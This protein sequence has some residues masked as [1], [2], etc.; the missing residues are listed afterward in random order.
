MRRVAASAVTIALLSACQSGI[1]SSSTSSA[2]TSSASTTSATTSAAASNAPGDW[3]APSGGPT[4]NRTTTLDQITPQNVSQLSKAWVTDVRDDGEE[5]SNPIETGDTVYITT[6]HDNVLA[7]DATSGKLKWAFGY[8]PQYELQYPVNRGVALDNGKLFLF[9]Q[10]CKLVALDASTGKAAF[11][12]PACHDTSNTWYSSAAYVYKGNVIVGTSGGD[13]G[14]DGLISAFS[15]T[16]GHRLWDWNTVTHPG[17][18][19]FGTWP[20]NSWQHGGA[21]VWAGLSAGADPDTIYAAPGNPEPNLTTYGHAGKNLY[22]DSVVALDISGSKPSLKWYHQIMQGDTHDADPAMPPVIFDGSVNGSQ[23]QLLAVGDKGGDFLIL[24]RTNGSVVY[25]M[26]V[27][28][29]SGLFTTHPTAQGTHACPNHGGG[30]EWN[31]GAYSAQTD[32]F[33]IPSTNHECADWKVVYPEAV[34]YIPGQP[35]SAGPL[36]KR[37]TASGEVHAID[38]NT[39]KVA[40]TFNMPYP[41]QGGALTTS[42]GLVFTSDLGGDV[43]A[44][45]AKTGKQLWKDNVGAAIVAPF[46]VYQASD[47]NEYLVVEAGEPGNQKVTNLPSSLGKARI[48][49]FRLSAGSAAHNDASGQPGVTVA[50]AST[51]NK[52]ES[53]TSPSTVSSGTVPYTQAQSNEGAALYQQ[54]CSSCHGTNLQGVS[55]PALDGPTFGR[56]HLNVSQMFDIVRQQMPLNAPGSLSQD[57]YASIMAYLLKRDCV[58]P[59]AGNQKFPSTNEPALAKTTIG[60]GSCS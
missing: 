4:N 52:T 18:P 43:Y 6:A 23:R 42:N 38:V 54:H 29:Q 44:L 11:N 8:D 34:P 39:G 27:S 7:L 55:A 25:K 45:D 9:T 59:S 5:E 20:G 32:M 28:N 15:E 33:Y 26:A 49:A 35:Y 47:G 12:V 40:W 24:D 53:G 2:T 31:G 48:V 36:P 17:E 37:N 3:P 41:G 50:N 30:I 21:A 58:K 10:D 57:N 46:A 60:S 1:Q 13:L 16:D 51:G 22:S 19:N 56:A 14:S